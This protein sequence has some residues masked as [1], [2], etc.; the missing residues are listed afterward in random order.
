M[1]VTSTPT[2]S[3]PPLPRPRDPMLRRMADAL[4]ALAMDAVEAAQSGHP[5]M[6]MGM[7]D[8]ATVLFTRFLAFDPVQ[9]DWPDRERFILSGGHGSILLFALLYLTGSEHMTIGVL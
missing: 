9:P 4:R 2:A 1:S 7:A 5:G 8:A 3:S 6:P